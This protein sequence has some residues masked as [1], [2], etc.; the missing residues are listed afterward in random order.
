MAPDRL[1]FGRFE[2]RMA[3]RA[4]LADGAPVALGPRAF[5]VLLA[6]TDLRG[7]LVTKNELM[8]RVWPDLVVEENNLQVQVSTL[9]KILGRDAIAT[10]P[11][12]GYQFTLSP[13]GIES[14]AAPPAA[15]ALRERTPTNLPE[16]LPP[17]YG[18]TDRIGEIT[19][20]LADHRLIGIVGPP[21]IGKTR[22]AQSVAF[23]VVGRWPDGVWLIE[24]VGVSDAS[25]VYSAIAAAV[26]I[27]LESDRPPA[28]TLVDGLRRRSML[29]V[30]D[31]CEHLLEPVAALVRALLER[32]PE[33]RMLITSQAPLRLPEERTIRL[34]GLALP[35]GDDL[36]VVSDSGAVALFDARASAAS[37]GF[38]LTSDNLG[39]VVRICRRLDGIPLAI[40]LAAARLP[41]LGLDG[42]EAHLGDRFKVLTG[43]LRGVHP[44][45]RT[46][47]SALN[48][49][50]GLLAPEEQKVFRRLGIFAG[51]F[52]LE[53]A[54]AVASDDTL[55]EWTVVEHLATLIDRSLVV[56]D[57]EPTPRYRLLETMRAYALDE[58]RRHDEQPALERRHALAMRALF[59]HM[60]R[61]WFEHPADATRRLHARE[62][63]NLR[64]ATDW[65]ASAAGDAETAVALTTDSAE[66]WMS[67]GLVHE[68]LHRWQRVQ[69][70]VPGVAPEIQLRFWLA[71]AAYHRWTS[72]GHAACGRAMAL[73][74]EL[75]DRRR[76]YLALAFEAS[77]AAHRGQE[78]EA[79]RALRELDALEDPGWPM[80]LKVHGLEARSHT[81]YMSGR[82]ED[83]LGVAS[84]MASVFSAAGD[85]RG[86]FRARLYHANIL[87][88]LER[89][90][91]AV[92]LGR[93]LRDAPGTSRYDLYA[94]ALMN[95]IEAL[96]FVGNVAEAEQTTRRL[97]ALHR[98]P[99]KS[100]TLCIG[101]L[102]A[103]LGRPQDAARLIGHGYAAFEKNGVPLEPAE[104]KVGERAESL[105]RAALSAEE[106]KR[107]IAEGTALDESTAIALSGLG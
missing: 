88:C 84:Q 70:L 46:L 4:L 27:A 91:E 98:M 49:S 38:R 61:A 55:D 60:D 92:A 63:H 35:A 16:H 95:L 65:A 22:L 10:V 24:L 83:T 30:L 67:T 93:E 59:E 45:H 96:L 53:L 82:F 69:A 2:L 11:G 51:G 85:S 78:A 105:L 75:K 1:C 20:L 41:I 18:R 40:E 43:G 104:F 52:S 47:R 58:L 79:D 94:V 77:G 100:R 25:A 99:L 3:E 13:D 31:N 9:R 56:A 101:L 62:L 87:F 103:H 72:E 21:G 54:R 15:R 14:A 32:A 19:R 64:A 28:V 81:T 86:Y 37:P 90:E 8:E 50:H 68:G 23:N 107:L 36:A 76:L 42:L 44:R 12:R 66:I 73:A 48:W 97:L 17:I 39:A 33:V 7:R 106:L 80:A 29:L 5:D 102:L 74:R 57:S 89:F 71:G 26:G 34:E 6:L